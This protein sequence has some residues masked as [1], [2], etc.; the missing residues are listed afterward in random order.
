MVV[1]MTTMT[2]HDCYEPFLPVTTEINKLC[3]C[4]DFITCFYGNHRYKPV[5]ISG[6]NVFSIETKMFILQV[7]GKMSGFNRFLLSCCVLG[8]TLTLFT[9]LKHTNTNVTFSVSSF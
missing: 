7:C 4:V 6:C 2:Q 8:T 9:L 1:S 5:L 3:G